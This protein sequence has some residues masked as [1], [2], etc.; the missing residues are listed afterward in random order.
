MKPMELILAIYESNRRG[1]EAI[2]LPLPG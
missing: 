1:G 2:K